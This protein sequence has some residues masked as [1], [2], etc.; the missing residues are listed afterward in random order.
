MNT[1]IRRLVFAMVL[2]VCVYFAYAVWS[3]LDKMGEALAHFHVLAFV[4]A[5]ALAFTNYIFRFFKWEFYLARL[6]IR[7]VEKID[8][9]LIFLSGFVLTVT[10]GKVGEV[11][12]SLILNETHGVPMTKTAPII[13]AERA[14]DVLGIVVL[15]VVG[16]L[17]FSGGLVWAGIGAALVLSLLVVIAN[18]KLSMSL[19]ALSARL[20]G[21]FGTMAPKLE[22]AY[23]SLAEMLRP[24]NLVV[25][26]ILSTMAW[27][28]E[29]LAL[30]VILKGFGEATSV[31]L[32]MFFYATSTLVGAVIPVPGGLGVTESSLMAQ[33]TELGHTEKSIATAAMILVRFATLWFAVIVGFVA[34]S[35]MKKRYPGLLAKTSDPNVKALEKPEIAQ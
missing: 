25:P 3:G 7:G 5:C 14:T 18:R 20:P 1:N 12:K 11:F 34:L 26:T 33:M 28:L 30:W 17:G 4:A 6:G 24:R 10:P 9:F 35:L 27:M 19:I 21:R 23:E 2:G 8:S 29:C 13:V 22:A 31:P 32:A 16:S 15:I